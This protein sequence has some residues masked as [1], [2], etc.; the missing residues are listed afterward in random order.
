MEKSANLQLPYIMPS[1]AQKHVT[2]NEAVRTLD[3]LVQLGVLDRDLSAPPVSPADGDRYLVASG[4]T[5]AWASNDGKVAA[6]QD[7]AWAFL[8]PK[9]GWLLWVADED[10]LLGFDGTAWIDAAVHSVN[11]AP[12]VGVNAT[13]DATNRLVVKSPASLFDEEAGDHRI[14]I[15]K[16]AAGDTASLVFQSAY[17]GRAEFGLAG[18]D[19][20]HVKVS[21]D[22]A[23]WTEALKVDR[24]TGRVSLPA[25]L[26]LGDENQVVT[27]RHVRGRLTADRTYHVRTDG[28]DSNNGLANTS[29][30]AFLTI[31]KAIDVA[32]TLD[33]GG[34][35]VTIQVADGAYTGPISVN[36]PFIGGTVS[37]VGNTTT[38]ANC[39]ISHNAYGSFAVSG[40]GVALNVGGL[41][42]QN[43][44]GSSLG[45]GMLIT[46]GAKVTIS[47]NMDFGA[48]TRY[49]LEINSGG[50]LSIGA[51]YTI[52]GNAGRHWS[53]DGSSL[54]LSGQTI[55][56]SGSRAFS[57]AFAAC[58]NRGG[59]T[60]FG[61]TK[62]GSAT[63][64]Y[65]EIALNGVI[66][67]FGGGAT[68][69]F[70]DT[71]GTTATGGQYA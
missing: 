18:D 54:T 37:L 9:A 1:Q 42:I 69:L 56:I 7:G 46:S 29:G 41:K 15:N 28:S 8:A 55:T 52:S 58:T 23:V 20:W 57:N 11:P 62:S 50:D 6:W 60:V 30:G 66:N 38:P 17:S 13:A 47:G 59:M 68:A 34:F 4:A 49:H 33:L 12:L 43:S 22:G 14:K 3:A 65:F 45:Q 63:G 36:K 64:K 27:Q 48:C 19:D 24:S 21:A 26:P 10:R 51:G 16:A 35:G 31:Q 40:G 70:G 39:I 53:V 61:L 5:D 32:W 44:A 25:A 67:T 2:H 71:T